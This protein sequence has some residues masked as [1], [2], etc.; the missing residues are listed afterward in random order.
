MSGLV[1]IGFFIWWS[2]REVKISRTDLEAALRAVG[3][4]ADLPKACARMAFH[5]A[6]AEVRKTAHKQHLLIRK[7]VKEK[8]NY[9]FGLVD[10]S[11]DVRAKDLTYY[12]SATM[13]FNPLTGV[14]ACDHTHRAYELIRAKYAEC[15]DIVDS[16]DVRTM[17]QDILKAVYRVSVRDRGG[18]YFVPAAYQEVVDKLER[19]LP[20]LGPDCVLNVAPQIDFDKTKNAI[21]KAFLQDLKREIAE[22]KEELSAGGERNATKKWTKRLDEF[23]ALKQKV[24]FYSTAMRFQSEDLLKEIGELQTAVVEKLQ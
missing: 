16:T 7:I 3:L 9:V 22:Y 23:K 15:M 24:E 18:I 13:T 12:Q 11:V 4:P 2:L 14:L 8:D 6:L 1:V 17:L 10:E 5:K 19:L 21:Y 20:V